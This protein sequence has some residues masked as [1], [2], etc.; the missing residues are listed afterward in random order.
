MSRRNVF[1]SSKTN[2]KRVAMHKIKTINIEIC[3]PLKK[4]VSEISQRAM[5]AEFFHLK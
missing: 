1:I 3:F 4:V 5:L 2:Q